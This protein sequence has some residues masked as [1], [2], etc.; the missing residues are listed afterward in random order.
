MSHKAAIL[1]AKASSS[2][3]SPLL[4]RQFSRSTARPGSTA[5][6]SSQSRLSGTC[7]PMSEERCLATG[8]SDSFSLNSPSVG[9]PR[10]EA[11]SKRAPRERAFRIP[12][13]EAR[14]R[15]SSVSL[16]SWI[17]TLK[18]TRM[19]TRLPRKSSPDIFRTAMLLRGHQRDSH[20]EHAVAEPPLVVVPGKDLHQRA[21]GYLGDGRVEHRGSG[22]V[23]EVARYERLGAVLEDALQIGLGGLLRSVVD[24][25]DGGRTLGDERQIDERHV[26]RR[27]TDRETVELP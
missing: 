26:D 12:G 20:V 17:G 1:F 3:F 15:V 16:P 19:K 22:V 18:S 24:F 5:T 13:S 9:R 7:A 14:M 4:K 10:C 11:S 21:A 25:L 23:V 2:F 27:H 6:P 8:A